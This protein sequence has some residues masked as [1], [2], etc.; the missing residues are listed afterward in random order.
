MAHGIARLSRHY[1][2]DHLRWTSFGYSEAE[3][4]ENNLFSTVSNAEQP[5][6][7]EVISN[8]LPKDVA[9]HLTNPYFFD[10]FSVNADFTLESYGGWY[11]GKLDWTL[12]RG[13][14]VISRHLDNNDFAA[15]DHKLLVVV[16][17][18]IVVPKGQDPGEQA[19]HEFGKNIG[20]QNPDVGRWRYVAIVL[21]LAF[22]ITLS[23]AWIQLGV[24]LW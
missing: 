12:L 23:I 1:C 19:H 11:R 14:R 7:N 21:V 3:W 2:C 24:K 22:P 4:W 5:R 18:P 15:S 13:F 17:A 6:N 8:L 9:K 20:E 10:P 16:V